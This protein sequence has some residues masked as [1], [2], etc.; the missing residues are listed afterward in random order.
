MAAL[1]RIQ[2]VD[3]QL[4]PDQPVWSCI[5]GL[6]VKVIQQRNDRNDRQLLILARYVREAD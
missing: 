3:S 6:T 2:A 1:Q 4:F 5:P